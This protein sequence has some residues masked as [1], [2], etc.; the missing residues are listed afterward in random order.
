M[1]RAGLK[2]I[3]ERAS[4]AT[5]ALQKR[6]SFRKDYNQFGQQMKELCKVFVKLARKRD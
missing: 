3:L 2:Q 1:A 5:P 6:V 4:A